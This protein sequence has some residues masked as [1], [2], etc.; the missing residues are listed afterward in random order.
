M[1]GKSE[2]D[3]L[4]TAVGSPLLLSVSAVEYLEMSNLMPYFRKHSCG[5][6]ESKNQRASCLN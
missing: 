5:L 1:N 2:M 3:Q 4:Q 6:R